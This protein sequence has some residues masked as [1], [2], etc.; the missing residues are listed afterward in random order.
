MKTFNIA[1][2]LLAGILSSSLYSCNEADFLTEINPN[3][4]VE[5]SFWKTE[6]DVKAALATVYNPIRGATYGYFGA[7]EGF[8]NLNTRADDIFATPN[9]DSES[10]AITIF[11]NTPNTGRNN[12]SDLYKGIQ[13]A[14]VFIYN[15]ENV[16]MDE[17]VKKEMQGEAYFLRGYQYFLLAINY[18]QA[19]IHT[20]P[21]GLTSGDGM[22]GLSPE[23]DVW[24][25][26]EADLKKAKELLPVTRPASE[27]GRVTKGAAIAHLGK[28][29]IFQGKYAEGANE[30]KIIMGSPYTY[31]LVENFEDNFKSDTEFNK[32]SIFELNYDKFGSDGGEWTGGEEANS[33]MGSVLANY[34]SPEGTGVGGWF[35]M[36]VSAHLVDEFTI[37]KRPSG[38]D[39]KWDKRIY[40]T[41]FFKYSDYG[42]VKPDETWYAN[43]DFDTMWNNCA[44][45]EEKGQPTFNDIEGVAG[46]FLFKKLSCWW[47]E[48]GATMYS[49]WDAKINNY[50]VMRFAEVLLLHAE[51][52]A[53]TG[54]ITSA[55]ADLKRIRERA[56]LPNKNFG[57]KEA[58]MKEIEHQK[59]L[60]F[61]MEGIRFFD[62]KRWYNYDQLKALFIAHKKQGAENFQ[63]KHFWLPIPQSEINANSAISQL[64]SWQ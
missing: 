15:T 48:K 2:Y 57:D 40:T 14:N 52:C 45:R 5:T 39:S 8:Q 60:E 55:N 22:K 19:V 6:A 11:N 33:M 51:A 16:P 7:Y 26:V 42:D 38:S 21:T 12:W 28:A 50:R 31:D 46:R 44:K 3:T 34:F 54:D 23:A 49:N 47:C 4:P 56:G 25:Q 63:P 64:P 53:Q 30:L 59:L 32:E 43:V 9:D 20:Q 41:F 24:A 10:W 18:G 61:P 37:E 36:Q 13:R 29:Y 17:T 62:L 35:K 1:K 58:L 27:N